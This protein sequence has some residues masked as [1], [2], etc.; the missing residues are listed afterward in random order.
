MFKKTVKDNGHTVFDFVSIGNNSTSPVLS[1]E[2]GKASKTKSYNDKKE[3][4]IIKKQNNNTQSTNNEQDN[5]PGSKEKVTELKKQK[6]QTNNQSNKQEQNKEQVTKLKPIKKP[7][8]QKTKQ[9]TKSNHD[10]Q[11]VNKN[12]STNKTQFS[13]NNGKALVNLKQNKNSINKPIDKASKKSFNSFLD[14]VLADG[15][16]ENTGANAES[17]GETLTATQVDQVRNTIRKCW[18][19][20]AG[21]KDA[22]TLV[23]DIKMELDRDGYVKK[24]EITDKNRMKHDSGFKIAAEN[25]QRA[26]LDPRCNPLPLPKEKYNEWKDLELS[27]N[28]KDMVS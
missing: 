22:D 8:N 19:F 13:K 25:A 21:L 12:N 17:L 26:V 6:E 10:K 2:S 27:F 15:D 24:A 23:V 4:N 16:N 1:P 28:P 7:N 9:L 3:D 5:H 18:H 20:P 14:N 11:K